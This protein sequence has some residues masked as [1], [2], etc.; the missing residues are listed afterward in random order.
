VFGSRRNRFWFGVLGL[1]ALA[2]PYGSLLV[3]SVKAIVDPPATVV[4]VPEVVVPAARFPV[5]A[6]PKLVAPAVVHAPAAGAP[7]PA[8]G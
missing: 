8:P 4:T 7:P 6:V 2:L 5:L 1:V 3:A